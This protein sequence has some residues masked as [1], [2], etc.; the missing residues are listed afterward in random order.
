M[1]KDKKAEYIAALLRERAGAEQYGRTGTVEEIDAEL[2]KIGH[3]A[4]TPHQ[5]SEKMEQPQRG[6]AD[7]KPAEKDVKDEP[8]PAGVKDNGAGWFI[9]PNGDKVRGRDAVDEA[10]AKLKK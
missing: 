5:R 4:S 2:K 1:N 8:L 7:A 6:D 3:G 10:L 9:L